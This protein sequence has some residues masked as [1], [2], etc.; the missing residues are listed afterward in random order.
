MVEVRRAQAHLN[1]TMH[2]ETIRIQGATVMQLI[3]IQI[4]AVM[5]QIPKAIGMHQK[6]VQLKMKEVLHHR[7]GTILN[8][9][10]VLIQIE[11]AEAQQTNPTVINLVG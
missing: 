1:R 7:I 2:Q 10:L 6:I 5:Q 4:V 3:R 11:T 8:Q 9:A